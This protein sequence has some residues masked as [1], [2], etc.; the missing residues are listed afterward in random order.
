MYGLDTSQLINM[1]ALLDMARKNSFRADKWVALIRLA[2]WARAIS[3]SNVVVEE[4]TL[5]HKQ[6]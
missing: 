2:G 4:E 5:I 6:N 3:Y 1:S